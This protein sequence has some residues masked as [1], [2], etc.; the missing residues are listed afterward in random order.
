MAE[1]PTMPFFTDAYLADTKHLSTLEHGAYFLLLISMWRAGGSLPDDATLLAR[2]AGIPPRN[3]HR[4]WEIIG[5][6]FQKEGDRL[7]QKKLVSTYK[8]A[9]EKRN[10]FRDN[11]K[12]GG[13][14]KALKNQETTL[15]NAS[16]PPEVSHPARPTNL[17][18]ESSNPNGIDSPSSDG[19]QKVTK[20]KVAE[21]KRKN[22]E[23]MTELERKRL[24]LFNG[25]K[26]IGV[27]GSL[28]GRLYN[29]YGGD[30]NFP[31]AITRSTDVFRAI[32]KGKIRDKR[33]YIGA[34]I[35]K[36]GEEDAQR[37]RPVADLW[38]K[39]G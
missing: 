9:I 17:N 19:G 8:K 28:C 16:N 3:W 30:K 2:Y 7:V 12:R 26:E 38:E 4:V 35:K 37:V 10:K 25:A 29:A 24:E 34:V 5:P 11:G 13:E 33:A 20:K 22:P 27:T 1:L 31:E 39:G 23:E 32:V 14:A 18:P 36:I 6:L 15:A 21:S